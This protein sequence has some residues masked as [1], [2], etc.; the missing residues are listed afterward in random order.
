MRGSQVMGRASR[1]KGA[2]AEREIV[3]IL[4][5]AGLNAERTAQMQCADGDARWGDVRAWTHGPHEVQVE[6]KRRADLP[7]WIYTAIGSGDMLVV[8]DPAGYLLEWCRSADITAI[9]ADRRPWLWIRHEYDQH[10]STGN[11]VDV[12][13]V[14][15]QAEG[16]DWIKRRCNGGE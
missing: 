8:R 2:R 11:A 15:T 3:S 9:R 7:R 6:V 14:R 4:R 13:V 5:S 1:D 16:I 12:V 10:S